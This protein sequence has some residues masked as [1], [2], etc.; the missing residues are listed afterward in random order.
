MLPEM[1][2]EE[3]EQHEYT[4]LVIAG[5]LS[6]V[7]GFL[8]AQA[9]FPSQKA[10]LAP[11]FASIPL[12]YPLMT[13]YLEEESHPEFF[14][15][16]SVYASLFIG[17]TSAFFAISFFT[18]ESFGI[19]LELLGVSGYATAEASFLSVLVNNFTVFTGILLAS[20]ILGS[21]GAFILV[22]NASVLGVFFAHLVRDLSGLEAVVSTSSPLAYLPHASLEMT[23]F[24]VAGILGTTA[25][26]SVYREHWGLEH[27][28][29][30][31]K[32]LGVGIVAIIAGAFIETV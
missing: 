24:I 10:V 5:G 30:L 19:Q 21:A 1:I 26:A 15:E 27:W 31:L 17:I 22:W 4:R 3:E 11:V 28:K 18:P 6:A 12:I 9:L 25:S 2:L 14:T 23:G 16:T 32:L 29:K 8:F 13:Y 20:F 7:A